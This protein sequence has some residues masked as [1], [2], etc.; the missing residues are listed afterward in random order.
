MDPLKAKEGME[1]IRQQMLARLMKCE[2]GCTFFERVSLVQVDNDVVIAI[3]QPARE[4]TSPLFLY[5]C[6]KCQAFLEPN[7]DK[8]TMDPLRQTHEELLKFMS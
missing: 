6:A 2:C 5:R 8:G 1:S 4:T 3:G 7:I